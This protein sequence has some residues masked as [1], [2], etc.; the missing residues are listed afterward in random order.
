MGP[1]LWFLLL[2][3][4]L[5][6]HAASGNRSGDDFLSFSYYAKSCHKFESI[7]HKKVNEWV[8]K[9]STL[10]AA[11]IRLH[12][13]DCAV[14]VSDYYCL[15]LPNNLQTTNDTN[16]MW[17]MMKNDCVLILIVLN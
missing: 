7:V 5:V 3:P 10:A 16:F 15:K 1:S 17:S 6:F 14:R 2:L 4:F 12:F 13:H 11:L 9:D 8:K